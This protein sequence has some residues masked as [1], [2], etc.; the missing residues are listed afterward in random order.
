VLATASADKTVRLWKEDGS[1][2]RTL[3]GLS[4]QVYALTISPD[5]SLVAGG[6]WDGEVR[7]WKVADGRPAGGFNASPGYQ[8]K[9]VVKP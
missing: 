7:I 3:S 4:D 9:A 2:L 1:P 5:G 8:P 6:S